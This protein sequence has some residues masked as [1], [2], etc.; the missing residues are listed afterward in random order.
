MDPELEDFFPR[1]LA[2]DLKDNVTPGAIA[3]VFDATDRQ[4]LTPLDIRDASGVPFE[5]NRLVASEKALYPQFLAP[6]GVYHVLVKSGDVVTEHAS[7]YGQIR[8]AGLTPDV[9]A[10]VKAERDAAEAAREEA[11]QLAESVPGRVDEALASS[12]ALAAVIAEI[13][14]PILAQLVD[15]LSLLR[16]VY[17]GDDLDTPRPATPLPVWWYGDGVPN[18]GRPID[19]VWR[20]PVVPP[21][22]PL[23]P[24]HAYWP[25]G[26][27][28]DRHD[29][30]H[31]YWPAGLV[32]V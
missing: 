24:S 19:P 25:N 32:A 13:A 30:T 2:L 5:N 6:D 11:R 28:I 20:V 26:L 16:V 23:A 15:A 4:M 12:E 29:P 7:F 27:V 18:Q 1:M 22:P 10:R 21:T 17:F 8:A 31:A 14:G 9:V 3:Q